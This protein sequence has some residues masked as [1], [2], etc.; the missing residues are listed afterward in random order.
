MLYEGCDLKD[1]EEAFAQNVEEANVL[2]ESCQQDAK[3]TIE[4]RLKEVDLS[5]DKKENSSWRKTIL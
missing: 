3:V 1:V 4:S 5:I 2:I